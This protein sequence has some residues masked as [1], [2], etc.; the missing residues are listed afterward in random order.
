MKRQAVVLSFK[1]EAYEAYG[2]FL[3]GT[4]S[5]D[6][7]FHLRAWRDGH[8]VYLDPAIRIFHQTHY[9]VREYLSHVAYH[10][11][12][13]RPGHVEGDPDRGLAGRLGHLVLTPALPFLLYKRPL[14]LV[15]PKPLL[16]IGELLDCL[17]LVFAGLCARAW[18]EFLGFLVTGPGEP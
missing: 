5:S 1:R 10:R 15:W 12:Y 6:T 2:P 18:G 11:R 16:F 9:N 7:A 8:K 14:A 13:L 3:E 4:Y 17:P